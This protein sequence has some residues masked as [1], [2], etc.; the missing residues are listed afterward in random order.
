M[1]N[2]TCIEIRELFDDLQDNA[3][4]LPATELVHQHLATCSDCRNAL[5]REQ[6]FRQRLRM[7]TV[8]PATSG[9]A[10]RALANARQHAANP[11]RQGFIVG[12]ASA[13][14]VALLLSVGVEPFIHGTTSHT[15]KVPTV[16]LAVAQPQT[17]RIV[18]TAPQDFPDATLTVALPKNMEVEGYPGKHKVVWRSSLYRGRNLL[19]LPLL[20]DRKPTGDLIATIRYGADVKTFH[21]RLQ[22]RPPQ[23]S[24][25]DSVTA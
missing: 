12:F 10:T 14:M 5:M 25:N 22:A 2:T 20:A 21:L 24:M 11:R 18:F 15:M 1:M 8:P 4:P 16:T 13:A 19:T 3:L 23:Q 17:V 6:A 7:Q 9:F